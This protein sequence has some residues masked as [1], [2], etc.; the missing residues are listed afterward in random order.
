MII[1]TTNAEETFKL[2]VKIGEQARPGEIYTLNGD[3]GVGKTVFTQGVARGLGIEEPVNSPTFTIV[4][5][6][7]EGKMPFYHFDVYRIGDIE[8]M[9]E[10][11]YDDYFFGNGVCLIEWAE[12]IQELLPKQIISV[13]IE[14]NPEKGFDYRKITIDG[15]EKERMK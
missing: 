3:L 2:G 14:K 12:L 6:Y 8:E 1:E 15:L 11:G 9:E 10:I 7:E 13:T 4:Q 5:V